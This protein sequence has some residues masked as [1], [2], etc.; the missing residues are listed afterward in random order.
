MLIARRIRECNVY[1]EIVPAG[2][3][4]QDDGATQRQGIRP[5]RRPGQRLRRE[6]AAGAVLHLRE[7]AARARHLLRDA[8]AGAPARRPRV[9]GREARVRPHRDPPVGAIG[10]VRRPAAGDSRLD[11]PRRPDH[12]DAVRLPL[13]RLLRQLARR[14]DGQR[15]RHARPPVPP[16]GRAHAA[17]Q[18]DHP[19]LPLPHLRLSRRLDAVE[20]RRGEHRA[21]PRAG[22]RRPRHLRPLRRRRL[23]GGG[24]ARAPR[25][26]RPAHLHL[27]QQRP[28][29]PRGAGARP[30][31]VPSQ[32]Q[33][34]PGLRRRHR[35]L[36]RRA[37]R[38]RRPRDEAPPRRRGVHPRLRGGGR[39]AGQGRLHGAGH[40]VPRR[41]RERARP[42][43]TA[44]R[45]RSR[46]TTTSAGC[47]AT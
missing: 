30:R 35:A 27:R 28:A 34:E 39:Q 9:A 29:A 31:H 41:H 13:P 14:G 3:P 7:G 20:L 22:G 15:P 1:C 17:G 38:R 26:R 12:A 32:S 10:A 6:R 8:A 18:A 2:A 24:D 23:G 36:P 44:R 42:A 33:D 43:A 5:L 47:P 11:E 4:W 25:R 40:D 45:R 16:G 19:Q 37:R 46:R 21:H